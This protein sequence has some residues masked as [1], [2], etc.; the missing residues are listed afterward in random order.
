M[1]VG[2][3]FFGGRDW[4]APA[5]ACAGV[6]LVLVAWSYVRTPA[7]RGLRLV[8]AALKLIGIAALLACLLEPMWTGERAKPGANLIAVVADN[9]LIAAAGV[10]LP[11]DNAAARAIAALRNQRVLNGNTSTLSDGWGN[12]VYSVGSDAQGAVNARD[13]H[14]TI[15]RE[16]DA[17]RDQ[18]SGVSLD[19]EALNLLKFQRAYEANAKFFSTI[20]SMLE[21]LMNSYRR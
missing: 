11:G 8:C 3:F 20:D 15:T 5:A 7:P 21:T 6:A 16:I 1:V 10:A 12:I 19:E 4:L 9:S 14:E 2:A 18:V 13:T 17:L